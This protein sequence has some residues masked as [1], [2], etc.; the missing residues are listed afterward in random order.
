M[1]FVAAFD[2]RD[3]LAV[4][5]DLSGQFT[6]LRVNA[7]ESPDLGAPEQRSDADEGRR[8]DPEGERFHSRIVIYSCHFY[9]SLSTAEHY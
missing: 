1:A 4:R 5:H 3:A 6:E 2:P 8:I 7:I 9:N